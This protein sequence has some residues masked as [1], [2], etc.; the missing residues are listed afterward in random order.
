MYDTKQSNGAKQ[1]MKKTCMG[2]WD[3]YMHDISLIIDLLVA[4]IHPDQFR[5]ARELRNYLHALPNPP[6]FLPHAPSMYSGVELISNRQTKDH[7]DCKGRRQCLDMLVTIG[8]YLK[9]EMRLADVGLRFAYP[10]GTVVAV[11]GGV[12]RHSVEAEGG[13]RICWAYFMRDE[14]FHGHGSAAPSW[15]S[16]DAVGK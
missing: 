5:A 1:I 16:L 8:P 2:S 12:V 6:S 4:S 14:L 7:V 13:E 11:A 9:A 3:E 15:A 10:S